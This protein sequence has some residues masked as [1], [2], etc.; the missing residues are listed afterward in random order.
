MTRL[1]RK[2]CLCLLLLLTLMQT[3]C[4]NW[5]NVW[6]HVY[7]SQN[8]P[9]ENVTVECSLIDSGRKETVKT[10]KD[11]KFMAQLTF[12]GGFFSPS[13]KVI[14]TKEGYKRYETQYKV[15]QIENNS[16]NHLTIVL[17]KAE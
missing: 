10:D 14:A 7:D 11:G 6:G 16:Q 3:S 5:E 4:D 17:E 15:K 12:G 1:S 9:I 2:M 8:K 13:V